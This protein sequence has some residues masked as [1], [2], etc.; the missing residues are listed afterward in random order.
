M[1]VV[2][3]YNHS[4]YVRHPT[5]KGVG[6]CPKIQPHSLVISAFSAHP[7]AARQPQ[8]G[9]Q[10]QQSSR[11]RELPTCR[12]Q[13]L[14]RL[15]GSVQDRHRKPQSDHPRNPES[16]R[17]AIP[18]RRECS[19][20]NALHVTSSSHVRRRQEDAQRLLTS[21]V[22]AIHAHV[23]VSLG[24]SVLVHEM[25]KEVLISIMH[26]P[27]AQ[28]LTTGLLSESQVSSAVSQFDVD[29]THGLISFSAI[30]ILEA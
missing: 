7:G 11:A 8:S 30:N 24:S 6:L 26:R 4:T 19:Q 13:P 20:P 14:E 16:T 28:V 25:T 27:R 1:V 10:P 12:C 21:V 23:H 29:S 3:L 22:R 18:S 2:G 17:P 5:Y 9:S 15:R